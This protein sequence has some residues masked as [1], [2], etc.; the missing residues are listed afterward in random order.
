MPQG[1]FAS[2][3]IEWLLSTYGIIEVTLACLV[4]SEL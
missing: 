3:I 2:K 4:G 1:R